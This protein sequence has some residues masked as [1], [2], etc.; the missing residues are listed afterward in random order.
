[1]ST[2][3]ARSPEASWRTVRASVV[4]TGLGVGVAS[5]AY[6][7]SVGALGVAAGLSI[8]QTC[9]LSVLVFTGGSQFAFVGVVAGGG[10]PMSGAASAVLL[11]A[12]NG[13][14][15]V[16][17]VPLLGVRGGRR[18]VAAQLTIDE[19]TAVALAN[20]DRGRRA[21]RLGFWVTGLAI[22]LLWNL[23]TLVG[24][25]VGSA[26]GDP[27][28]YGLDA[29]APAAF[30]ALLAPRLRGRTEWT[31][32]V[33]AAA[34]ALVA[35]PLVPAGLPVLVAA[36][37]PVVM[38]LRHREEPYVDAAEPDHHRVPEVSDGS[39]G[40]ERHRSVEDGGR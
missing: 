40:S 2:E 4:R 28:D 5:G 11:G 21:G 18:L 15:G 6:A 13:L 22:F 39:E 37:V 12:R 29:A 7:L 16:R 31:A 35:V 19:S 27:R 32:A 8:V 20:E 24:A 3:P 14:Y 34:V 1:V 36:G 23:G 38:V 9:A 10:S 26:V 30:L 17:L 25:V 33:L